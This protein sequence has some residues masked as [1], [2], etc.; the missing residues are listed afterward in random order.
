MFRFLAPVLN[1]N[2][3]TTCFRTVELLDEEDFVEAAKRL[4]FDPAAI[5]ALSARQSLY[6]TELS[7]LPSPGG[8]L[9]EISTHGA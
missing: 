1:G 7:T 3:Y 4:L 2:A 5:H 9:L 6:M 8:R